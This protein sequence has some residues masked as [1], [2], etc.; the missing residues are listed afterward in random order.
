MVKISWL[1]LMVLGLMGCNNVVGGDQVGAQTVT[2]S[3]STSKTEMSAYEN[4]LI[5]LETE[6]LALE[7]QKSWVNSLAVA[8][9]LLAAV[10]AYWTGQRLQ[11]N[12]VKDNFQLQ[13]AQATDNFQLKAAEIA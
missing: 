8:I 11:R 9:P 5:Q 6:K 3:Q 13:R 2:K 10:F 4:K 1:V 7:R 12:Q